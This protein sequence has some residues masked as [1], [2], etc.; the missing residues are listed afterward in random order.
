[1]DHSAVA[2]NV[3]PA[4][5]GAPPAMVMTEP[6]ANAAVKGP[7]PMIHIM[8]NGPVDPKASNFEVT[9]DGSRVDVGEAM[10]MGATMLMAMPKTPL[11]AGAYRVKWHTVAS[12]KPLEGE[13]S[14]SVQ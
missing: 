8:F 10:P 11:P 2:A 13:F 1:M 3:P 9:K 14:F 12:S 4:K 6:A 5:P 7:V